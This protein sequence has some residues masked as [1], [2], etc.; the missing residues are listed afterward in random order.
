MLQ[1][2]E[3][4]AGVRVVGMPRGTAAGG[5]ERKKEKDRGYYMSGGGSRGAGLGIIL[6]SLVRLG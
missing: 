1:E 4:L 6:L 5:S 2:G 3:R